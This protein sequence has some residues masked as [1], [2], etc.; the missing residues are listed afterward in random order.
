M[1]NFVVSFSHK[2]FKLAVNSLVSS[3]EK[4]FIQ[5]FFI[6]PFSVQIA[7][8]NLAFCSFTVKPAD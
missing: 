2:L 1:G 4:I 3:V 5:Q 7:S 6:L 8:A